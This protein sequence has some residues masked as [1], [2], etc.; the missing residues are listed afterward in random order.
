MDNIFTGETCEQATEK[1]NLRMDYAA[2]LQEQIRLQNAKKEQL[3]QQKLDE[4]RLEREEMV[5]SDPIYTLAF[6]G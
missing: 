4:Q 1:H 5:P 2:V 3:K 6:G